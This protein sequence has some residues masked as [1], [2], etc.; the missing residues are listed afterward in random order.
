MKRVDLYDNDGGLVKTIE[1]PELTRVVFWNSRCFIL[2][3]AYNNY[4]E[5]SCYFAPL[6]GP[7]D[8]TFSASKNVK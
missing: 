5:V 4:V 1:L 8:L 2:N 3:P 6:F 7:S